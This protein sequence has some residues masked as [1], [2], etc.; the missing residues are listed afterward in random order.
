MGLALLL[1][2][3]CSAPTD[4]DGIDT[5]EDESKAARDPVLL[6]SEAD[7][8][9]TSSDA[10]DDSPDPTEADEADD[11]DDTVAR[12]ATVHAYVNPVAKNCADPG[13]IR[14][15]SGASSTFLTACTGK[16]FPLLKSKDL[17][18]W[19]SAGTNGHLMKKAPKWANG[20]Y[21]AP[22][23]HAIGDHYVAYFSANDKAK[24]RPCIGAATS[25]T[26][27]GPFID[28]GR[29]L[30]CDSKHGLIDAHEMNDGDAG[31]KHFLYYKT[32][33]DLQPTVIYGRRLGADGISFAKGGR[34]RLIQNKLAWEHDSVEGAWTMQRGKYTYL[35]YSGA[36]YCNDSYAVGVARA[37]SPLGPFVK[38]G[39]PI[40]K[41]NGKWSGPGHNSIVHAG[42]KTYIVYHAWPGAHSC[43]DSGARDLLLDRV[44]WSGGWP[45]I[46]NGTPSTTKKPAPTP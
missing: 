32:T 9:G 33:T 44:T 6:E 8:E 27:E 30:L 43:N 5:T 13:V 14:L 35:F 45:V 2:T 17:V 41:S 40:L 4:D 19:S 29:P 37:T 3:G 16:D 26:A 38:K 7:D 25:A 11:D 28:I 46:G 42:G 15:G 31:G 22:E 12:S 21:W 18:D 34:H 23:I 20:K 10:V 24:G 39:A 36:A 1:A